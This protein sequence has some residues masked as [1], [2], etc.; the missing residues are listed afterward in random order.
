MADPSLNDIS[1]QVLGVDLG[2]SEPPSESGLL[3]PRAQNHP[4]GVPVGRVHVKLSEVPPPDWVHAFS[5]RLDEQGLEGW[6]RPE[7]VGD[8][9]LIPAVEIEKKLKGLAAAVNDANQRTMNVRYI[10]AQQAR[11]VSQQNLQWKE[12]LASEA[13]KAGLPVLQTGDGGVPD[14]G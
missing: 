10:E 13:E 12:I 2:R 8:E 6:N 14:A 5:A 7:V 3:G 11:Q 1:I 9:I 4:N